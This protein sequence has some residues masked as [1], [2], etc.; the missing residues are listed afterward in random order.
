MNR[1]S[2]PWLPLL[3]LDAPQFAVAVGHLRASRN[4]DPGALQSYLATLL[5]PARLL[6]LQRP[7][8]AQTVTC[9]KR[10]KLRLGPTW[11]PG[12]DSEVVSLDQ[13]RRL[14][15]LARSCPLAAA[16]WVAFVCSRRISDVIRAQRRLLLLENPL[17]PVLLLV[18]H[19]TAATIGAITIHL[20][21]TLRDLCCWWKTR[22]P[23]ES[24]LF[25]R[26]DQRWDLMIR[27]AK[28]LYFPTT[29]LR[30]LR[31][32]GLCTSSIAAPSEDDL[33]VMSD[34]RN[35]TALRTYLGAGMLSVP[36][37]RRQITFISHNEAQQNRHRPTT[38]RGN[39][40]AHTRGL[41][42]SQTATPPSDR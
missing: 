14:W 30:G 2:F 12:D 4:Y 8:L 41:F 37:R 3:L 42:Q 18:E 32:G 21:Q 29:D 35:T 5:T 28:R 15:S 19:K 27:Q 22:Y 24:Y 26:P 33:L 31:R 6:A 11:L 9:L 34:H 25:L 36:R 38:R 13:A 10:E 16:C 7:W 39:S 23:N 40:S 17:G 1:R 20:T